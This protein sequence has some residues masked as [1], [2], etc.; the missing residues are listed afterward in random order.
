VK[1]RERFGINVHPTYPDYKNRLGAL[2]DW[3]HWM[4]YVHVRANDPDAARKLPGFKVQTIVHSVDEANR[5]LDAGTWSIEIDNEPKKS[6]IPALKLTAQAIVEAVGSQC[7]I[8]QTALVGSTAASLAPILGP[9]PG[10]Q[11]G[12]AHMYRGNRAQSYW[13]KFV[14]QVLAAAQITAPWLPV[15]VTERGTHDYT[16][17]NNGG[18]HPTPPDVA[19]AQIVPEHVA[20]FRAGVQR[21]YTY[22]AFDQP[23]RGDTH[24]AHFGI[25]G[26]PAAATLQAHLAEFGDYDDLAVLDLVPHVAVVDEARPLAQQLVDLLG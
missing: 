8:V 22:E 14:A 9:R 20:L 21:V 24:E 1:Y 7:P 19:A 17:A 13:D 18:H 2:V 26:K 3:L 6:Q 15:V 11:Y 25:E 16:G 4:G 10:T 23:S 12:N 5:A